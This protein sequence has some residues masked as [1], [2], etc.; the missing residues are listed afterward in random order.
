MAI[1]YIFNY[2]LDKQIN[3]KWP[4]IHLMSYADNITIKIYEKY[5]LDNNI[6]P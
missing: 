2:F 6:A 1:H 4:G 3:N 5:C